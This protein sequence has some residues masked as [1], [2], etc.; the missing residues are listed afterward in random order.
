MN[1]A[2]NKKLIS[3][4]FS[5]RNEEE[6][7]P[8]LLS[9][10]TKMFD[11]HLESKYLL[12]LIFVND[13]SNDNSLNLLIEKSKTIP[14]KVLNMS[15]R[16]GVGPCVIAGLE[17]SKGDAVIYMDSDLQDPPEL[18]P[19]LI[20]KFESGFDV[21]HTQRTKRLGENV[22]KMGVT[23]FAYKIINRFADIELPVNAGDFKLLSRRAVNEVLNMKEKDPY[24]R[25]LSVW[26]GFKQTLIQYVRQPRYSGKTQFKVLSKGPIFE[27]VRGVT[28]FST[29]ILFSSLLAGFFGLII[30]FGLI[31]YIIIAK[32]NGLVTSGI[33]TI[34]LTV[35]TLSSLILISNGILSIYVAKLFEQTKNRPLYV[36][37]SIHTND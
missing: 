24:I 28:S 1:N 4:I 5:F 20:E 10:I 22:F 18:I 26:V 12:E 11:S 25:G 13:F 21:V 3:I 9:R 8:E 7:L 27:F 32:F 29:V 35:S 16:F 17:F 31:L 2:L 14:I 37:E 33:T 30:S 19:E 15:R 23:S 6:N 34:V 36:V